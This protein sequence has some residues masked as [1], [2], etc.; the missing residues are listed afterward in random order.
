MIAFV[1]NQANKS[2]L[3][4]HQNEHWVASKDAREPALNP[5]ACPDHPVQR[6]ADASRVA[7]MRPLER[8]ER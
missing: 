1:V 2:D 4:T 6:V 7:V 3:L 8:S 5:E